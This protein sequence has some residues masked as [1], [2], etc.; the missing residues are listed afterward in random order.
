[1]ENYDRI[2]DRGEVQRRLGRWALFSLILET[3][4]V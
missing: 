1:M 2:G 3:F 4:L